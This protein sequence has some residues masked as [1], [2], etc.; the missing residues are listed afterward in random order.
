[1]FIYLLNNI[2]YEP[3]KKTSHVKNVYSRLNVRSHGA[4]LRLH[5]LCDFSALPLSDENSAEEKFRR[6][7]KLT[8]FNIK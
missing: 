4:P 5:H 7:K 3:K 8:I 1:M 2:T 6:A